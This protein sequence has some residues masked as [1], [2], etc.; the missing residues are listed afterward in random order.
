MLGALIAHAGNLISTT[1]VITETAWFIEDR[2]GP[3][4]EAAFLRL[5]IDDAV[6]VVDLNDQDWQRCVELIETYTSLG[7]GLVDA[8]VIAIA[9]RLEL[10]EIATMNT[11]DFTV[12][13]PRHCLAFTLLP[14]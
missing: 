4:R 6:S 8:S 13:K 12:V 3:G 1:P 11:R 5:V 10:N 14:A 2:H 9:E 7:L